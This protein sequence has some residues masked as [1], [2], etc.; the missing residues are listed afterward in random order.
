MR[1]PPVQVMMGRS[2]LSI[3]RIVVLIVVGVLMSVPQTADVQKN[4]K[5]GL[6]LLK[7]K[8][9]GDFINGMYERFGSRSIGADHPKIDA[10]TFSRDRASGPLNQRRQL[11]RISPQVLGLL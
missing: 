2:Q 9:G 4:I 1:N 7:D 6:A 3:S 8:P 5:I 10:S 11:D